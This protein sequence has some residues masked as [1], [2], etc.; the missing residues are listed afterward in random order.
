MKR[1]A[2]LALLL[3]LAAKAQV[4]QSSE[5]VSGLGTAWDSHKPKNGQCPVCGHFAPKFLGDP[6]VDE[7]LKR[8]PDLAE[9]YKGQKQQDL[10]RC[11]NCN[12]AF[13]RDQ[14]RL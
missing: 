11:R 2:W 5:K 13:Y 8:R 7:I 9:K 3:P 10:T 6:S 1:R 14:E 12:V 4:P